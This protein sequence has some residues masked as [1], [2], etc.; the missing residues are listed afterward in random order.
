MSGYPARSRFLKLAG[1]EVHCLEWGDPGKPGVILWHGFARNAHDFTDLA[2]ALAPHYHLVAPDTIGRG[3][4]EWS[5]APVQEYSV[6]FYAQQA[7]ELVAALGW[8]SLRWVGTS[9]GGI[10]GM[11]V[12][13]TLLKDKIT[14]LVLNDVGPAIAPGAVERILTYASAPPVFGTT[15]ELEVYF[16]TIY[17]PFG[18]TSDT[19]WQRLTASSLRRLPDGRVTTH[20]DPQIATAMGE[21]VKAAPPDASLWPL[22]DQI[23]ARTLL[24]RGAETD[25]LPEEVAAD[26]TRRGPR[27]LRVDFPGIGHA[28]ALDQA[29][30]I[31]LI[32]GFLR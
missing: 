14:H 21:Q 31:A 18:I 28:P 4:S 8:Q 32:A 17:A 30:Q 7:G 24:M 25:L 15:S 26:M 13:A 20:Y 5:L 22:Y 23:T 1:R 19:V 10:I 29:D 2:E 11:A 16:R 3:L 12:A 6:P 27:A 9:M